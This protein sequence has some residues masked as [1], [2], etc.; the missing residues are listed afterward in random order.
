MG[1]AEQRQAERMTSAERVQR[2]TAERAQRYAGHLGEI[3]RRRDTLTERTME[4]DGATKGLRAAVGMAIQQADPPPDSDILDAADWTADQ[5][6]E[7]RATLSV[8]HPG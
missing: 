6:A 7:L 1:A 4:L 8:R 2:A 3:R 5:L